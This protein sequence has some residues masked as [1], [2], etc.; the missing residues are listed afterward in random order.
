[1]LQ[2][3]LPDAPFVALD[4]AGAVEASLAASRVAVV[5]PGLGTGSDAEAMLDRLL[6]GH[7]PL[8]L[9]ADALNLL[10]AGR[11]RGVAAL[12]EAGV[13]VLTPH[14]GEA[15]RLLGVDVPTVESD[16]PASAG[17]LADLS[18]G[19]VVLKG[20]PALVAT[21]GRPLGISALASSD[22]AVAG[23]GDVL[24]GSLGAFIAQGLGGGDAA[25]AALLTGA[26][27]AR[28]TG[29]GAGLTASDIPDALP[30]ALDEYGPGE[31]DLP[32]S[33]VTLDLDPP[34]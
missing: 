1:V 26:R 13:R 32:F 4:D 22:L 11:P 29:L 10:A 18:G 30:G 27:A 21:P 8:V 2:A 19:V 7:R 24:A 25:G 33:W 23:M 12:G 34:R 20:T 6:A 31:T 28:R 5:G 3:T 9:D 17:R 16:R 14:P 15:A